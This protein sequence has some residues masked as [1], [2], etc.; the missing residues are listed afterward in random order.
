MLIS[1]W[2]HFSTSEFK[3]S[4]TNLPK[5][6]RSLSNIGKGIPTWLLVLVYLIITALSLLN[7]SIEES[8]SIVLGGLSGLLYAFLLKKEID[9]GA[10]M[11]RLLSSIN[12]SLTPKS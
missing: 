11:H 5:I 4:Y 7:L 3:S 12:N 6:N 9:L 2:L 1:L 10:W 8:F